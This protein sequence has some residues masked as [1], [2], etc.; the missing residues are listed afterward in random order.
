MA[1]KKYNPTSPARRYMS[2]S[3]FEEITTR[4][5]RTFAL[6]DLRKSGGRK[7]ERA[8]HRPPPGR[9][10]E[11]QIQ[12]HRLQAEQGRR[13][14]QSRDDRVRPEPV[15][16]HRAAA[17]CRRRKAPISWLRSDSGWARSWNRAKGADIKPGNALPIKAIP[18]GTTIHNIEPPGAR[19][20]CREPKRPRS[21]WPRRASIRRYARLQGEVRMIPLNA[22]AMIGQVGNLTTRT[23][24]R[25]GRTQAPPGLQAGGARF[26]DE[27]CRPPA[28]RRRGQGAYWQARARDALGCRARGTR[29]ARR[30]TPPTGS[31]SSAEVRNRPNRYGCDSRK[32]AQAV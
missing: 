31:S 11:A 18:V 12:N 27:P 15:G 5:P 1:I 6:T 17:L 25:E 30:R 14:G 7:R 13:S 19:Q 21:S 26:R 24:P 22:K 10:G 2:V 8:H 3:S 9:R 16:E 23:S 28:R 32:E 29:C 20:L 4:T